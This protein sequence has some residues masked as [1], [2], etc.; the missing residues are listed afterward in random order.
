MNTLRHTT[1]A[2][3][4]L[5]RDYLEPD[6]MNDY[7]PE[8]IQYKEMCYP[9]ATQEVEPSDMER[10]ARY[11]GLLVQLH[12]AAQWLET[13]KKNRKSKAKVI[14]KLRLCSPSDWVR[15]Q[16]TGQARPRYWGEDWFTWETWW[17]SRLTPEHF[18][19]KAR[20][21]EAWASSPIPSHLPCGA[22]DAYGDRQDEARQSARILRACVW[23][24]EVE[25]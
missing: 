15:T 25:T 3:L 8:P 23:L 14:K 19:K 20:D 13:Y 9:E 5:V 24:M 6:S 16:A 1:G 2:I 4:Q 21:L 12:D 7:V 11:N 18:L 10:A 17:P 22:D